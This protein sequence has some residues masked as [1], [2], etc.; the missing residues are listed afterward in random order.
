MSVN[1]IKD[2]INKKLTGEA[3]ENA[4]DFINYLGTN[5]LL[6]DMDWCWYVKY[7]NEKLFHI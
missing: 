6:E 7:K 2:T 5:V 1:R 4:L 3:K